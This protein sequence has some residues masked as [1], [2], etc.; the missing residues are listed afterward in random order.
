MGQG[1]RPRTGTRGASVLAALVVGLGGCGDG[2]SEQ[3]APAAGAADPGDATAPGCTV[4][5]PAQVEAATGYTVIGQEEF[6]GGCRWQL[7]PVEQ[8]VIEAAISWQ[9]WSIENFQGQRQA[10]QA[11]MDVTEVDGIGDEAF[12]VSSDTGDHPLGEV[13][14]RVG[15]TA[16][17]ITNEFSTARMEGSLEVQ[18]ALAAVVAEALA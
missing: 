7:E 18:Q 12:T 2:T 13:W 16:F 3:A 4:A 17:R 8:D 1:M 15:D 9:P 5:S 14:V 11:G 10:D 6:D